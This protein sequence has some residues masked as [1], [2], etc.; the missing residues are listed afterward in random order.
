[1]WLSVGALFIASVGCANDAECNDG[2]ELQGGAC[3][4]ASSG[5]GGSSGAAG[6]A[7]SGSTSGAAG[8]AGVAGSSGAA[9]SAGACTGFDFGQTCSD[10]QGH[11]DCGC[12]ADYCAVQPGQSSG[13]CTAAGCKEDPSI[14]PDGWTCLDLSV[15]DPSLP[16]ICREP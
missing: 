6:T 12:A 5:Q 3:V 4:P 16:S 14:C 13:Y 9:G 15:F 11:T 7:G 10:G 2:Q 1:M 8:T